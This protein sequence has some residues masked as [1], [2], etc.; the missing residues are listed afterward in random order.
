M[1]NVYVDESPACT[2]A[3]CPACEW[4][5]VS[6]DRVWARKALIRHM[7][8]YQ[9]PR[10]QTKTVRDTTKMWLSRNHQ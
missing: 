4:R 6:T 9:H 7:D 3:C 2:V 1:A 8:V 5:T 10:E